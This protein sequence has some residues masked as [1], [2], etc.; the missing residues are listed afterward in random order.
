[1][2]CNRVIF[3]GEHVA[4]H[5][6]ERAWAAH[7]STSWEKS[8]MSKSTHERP[9]LWVGHISLE[10]SCLDETDSFMRTI[11]MRSVVKTDEIAIL[12]LRGG[13]H[14]VLISKPTIDASEAS[15]DLMVEDLDETHRHYHDL[16]LP[17]SDISRGKI[18][19]WFTVTE[20]AGNTIKVN[21]TH[22]GD[23]PV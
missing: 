13:T 15:F 16:G 4:G 12:E 2:S 17:I 14:I 19:D 6:L 1:M 11:G 22:V 21:S 3:S 8:T 5:Q 9:P 23:L 20:P 18:H 7:E 10:T